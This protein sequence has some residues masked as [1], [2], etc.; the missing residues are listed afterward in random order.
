M[1]RYP[2]GWPLLFGVAVEAV[3][4]VASDCLAVGRLSAI[5][6]GHLAACIWVVSV[7]DCDGTTVGD[8][9]VP[10]KVLNRI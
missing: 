9:V 7:S 10:T 6:P 1:Y 2:T 4:A 8:A 5:F 3:N